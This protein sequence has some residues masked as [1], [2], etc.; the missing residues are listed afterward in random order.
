MAWSRRDAVEPDRVPAGAP[1]EGISPAPALE[2]EQV[3]ARTAIDRA[4]T[5]AASERVAT[6]RNLV[7]PGMTVETEIRTG[8]NTLIE[9]L[10]KPIYR[11]IDTGFR[12]R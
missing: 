5:G 3:V 4:V 7:L 12:E 2:G 9:Y 1:V 10:L 6:G 11:A 8:E